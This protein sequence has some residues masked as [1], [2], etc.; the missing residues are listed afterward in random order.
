[1][2]K[3]IALIVSFI[4]VLQLFIPLCVSAAEAD[5]N[6]ERIVA[7]DMVWFP[8]YHGKY[9][10]EVDENGESHTYFKYSGFGSELLYN[11]HITIKVYKKNYAFGA[12]NVT[13]YGEDEFELIT[14]QRYDNPWTQ[15]NTYTAQ[16][17]YKGHSCNVNITIKDP[18]YFEY[19]IRDCGAYVTG[20]GDDTNNLYVMDIVVPEELGGYPVVGID[21]IPLR[22]HRI[23][24]LWISDTV[25]TISYKA[26][27]MLDNVKIIHLGSSVKDIDAGAFVGM[28]YLSEFTVSKDSPYLTV[29]DGVLYSKDMKKFIAYPEAKGSTY[30]LDGRAT[31]L[32]NTVYYEDVTFK[33]V[34]ALEL[35]TEGTVKY[36]ADKKVLISCSGYRGSYVMPDTVEQILPE[37]F[38]EAGGL[39][40][41]VVSKNV[42]EIPVG[43]FENNYYL[44]E[45]TL[46][47]GLEAI[48][49]SAFANCNKLE[50]VNEI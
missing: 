12:S 18:V 2:K 24:S 10:T 8:G 27:E 32:L 33:S 42:K 36:T 46:P 5:P 20:W 23:D 14:D 41:V 25:E 30:T 39:T 38:K 9:V 29:V 17:V 15:G 50:S 7:D 3:T 26:L 11:P 47:E 31:D 37:A 34:N 43:A 16:I 28:E 4:T 45:V 49:K 22:A 19:E 35:V 40:S 1:M 44:E 6:I 21:R 48:G 13:F